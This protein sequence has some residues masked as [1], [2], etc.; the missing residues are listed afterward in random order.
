MARE[1]LKKYNLN[2]VTLDNGIQ[3]I[4]WFDLNCK[5]DRKMWKNLLRFMKNKPTPADGVFVT[6]IESFL[7]EYD[8]Y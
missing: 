7:F 6:D 2:I 4:T 5:L 1:L 3:M 8:F